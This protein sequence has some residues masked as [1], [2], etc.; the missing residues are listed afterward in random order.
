LAAAAW[1]Q[2]RSAKQ[3]SAAPVAEG[4]LVLDLETIAGTEDWDE[5]EMVRREFK[6]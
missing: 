2:I 5:D 4:A 3:R 6:A 1:R